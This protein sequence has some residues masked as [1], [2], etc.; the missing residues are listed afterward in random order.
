M[1]ENLFDVTDKVIVIPGGGGVLG[2]AMAKMLLEHG[3]KV[4]IL[5]LHES[6]VNKKIEELKAVSNEVIGFACDVTSKEQLERVNQKILQQWGKIDVLINAAGGNM[7]GATVSPEQ[8]VF[9]VSP[10]ALQKV[11]DLNLMGSVLPTLVFGKAM[12]EQKSGSI[13]NISSMAATHSITRVLGYSIA[14]AGIDMLTKWMAMELA[15]KFGDGLRVNAIAPGFFIG[16]QNERLLTNEDGSLTSRG[17]TIIQNTPM[18]RFGD[19]EELNGAVL[20]L[21]SEA[22]RFVTGTIIPVDGGFSSFSGV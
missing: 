8:T 4:A 12:A 11:L 20:Y 21:C 17:N 22:S 1:K 13:I 16:K 2:G 19:A 15:M 10:E 6:S 9:D 5:S 7:P 3:A 18:Q 14:K